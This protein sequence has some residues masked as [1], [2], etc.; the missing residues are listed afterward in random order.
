[1]KLQQEL[2]IKEY[3]GKFEQFFAGLKDMSDQALESKF[4]CGLKEDIQSEMR[5]LNPVGLI[6]KMEMAQVIEDDLA[7]EM[8]RVKGLTSHSSPNSKGRSGG[9]MPSNSGGSSLTSFSLSGSSAT[10]MITINPHRSTSVS[11]TTVTPMRA[12]AGKFT[13]TSDLYQ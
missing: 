1:M 3:R 11:L 10:R 4:V 2:S 13:P 7:I 5:K 6:A 9:S 8:K 12:T